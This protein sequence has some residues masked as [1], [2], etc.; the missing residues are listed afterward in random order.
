M[1]GVWRKS[2]L[3]DSS[4]GILSSPLLLQLAKGSWCRSAHFQ[5]HFFAASKLYWSLC[6]RPRVMW[7]PAQLQASLCTTCLFSRCVPACSAM[8][9]FCWPP[10]LCLCSRY[11]LIMVAMFFTVSVVN[12]YALNLN[13]AMPLH[14]IFRSVSTAMLSFPTSCD[15]S[16]HHLCKRSLWCICSSTILFFFPEDNKILCKNNSSLIVGRAALLW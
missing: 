5:F 10:L 9:W 14:M 16:P 1:K 6:H 13:I 12:N 4:W 7:V 11:Y 2:M 15:I 8:G 3:R